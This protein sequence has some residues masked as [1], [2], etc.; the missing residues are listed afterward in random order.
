MVYLKTNLSMEA[1]SKNALNVVA[2]P[3]KKVILKLIKALSMEVS[4]TNVINR[5]LKIKTL[6]M[7]VSSTDALN[8]VT[9]PLKNV[10]S[11]PIKLGQT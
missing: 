8:V 6:S 2:R 10:I 9:R 1:L 3:L 11:R 7:E 5:P 4:S